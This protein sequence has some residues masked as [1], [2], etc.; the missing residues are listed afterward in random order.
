MSQTDTLNDLTLALMTQNNLLLAL[1]RTHPHRDIL[2][3]SFRQA[4]LQFPEASQMSAA[5][6]DAFK[7]A[8]A[9]TS[10]F[11]TA[12]IAPLDSQRDSRA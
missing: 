5:N 7:L 12:F 11:E 1:I 4:Q 8:V 2:A 3:T 6:P 9:T 10:A